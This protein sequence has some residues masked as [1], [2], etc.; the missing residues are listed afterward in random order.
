MT[1]LRSPHIYGNVKAIKARQALI[2]RARYG[3]K[4]AQAILK[5]EG[6]RG[7]WNPKEQRMVR[8]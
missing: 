7:L 2:D 1:G 5:K 4:E 8:F 3:D 6:V